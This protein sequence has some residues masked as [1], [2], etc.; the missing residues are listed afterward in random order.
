MNQL[1][2]RYRALLVAAVMAV[3]NIAAG[4]EDPTTEHATA[5]DRPRVGLVLGGGGARGVAHIGVLKELERLRIPIDAIAGTSMGAIVGGLYASGMSA[6]ELEALVG[7]INWAAALR[8]EPAR[9]DLRFRRKEDEQ[10]FPI[11]PDMGI[12]GGELRLPMGLIQGQKLDLILRELTI[13]V[14]TIEDFDE[15]PIPFRAVASDIETG[16][17]YVMGQGDLAV[18]IRASMSVPGAFAPVRVND[19]MLVDGGLAGNLPID[20][21]R[22]MDVDVVIAVDVEFPLY[23]IDELQSA[24]AISEQMLT[25]LIRKETV[26]QIETLGN[27]DV[28]I[29][30][31][32]GIYGSA[33]FANIGETIGPGV[34]AAR[35]Q[36]QTLEHLAVDE[37][38][39]ADWVRRRDKPRAPDGKLAFVRVE[40]DS[41]IETEMI[42]SRLRVHPGDPIDIDVL[43]AE[44]ARLH[45]LAMFEK[46]NYRLV[47][48]DGETG[49]VFDARS[50][51]WGPGFL[52]FGIS[53][54]DD[55]EGATSFDARVR[56][57]RP[58][59]NGLGGEW[60]ADLRLG[61]DPQVFTEFYQ[62]L[63]FDSRFF[64][65]PYLDFDQ[66]NLNLFEEQKVVGRLRIS[67]AT[68]G[69][70]LGAEFGNIGEVR[71]GAFRGSGGSRVIV[72]DPGIPSPDFQTGGLRALLRFD[73]LDKAWFPRKGLRTSIEWRQS[74]PDFGADNSYDTI[75]VALDAFT[76]R[77]KTTLGFGMEYATTL[78]FDGAIQDL[79]RLGGFQRLSGFE[80][81]AVNGPHAALAKVLFYRR[82][83]DSPAG[84][85]DAPVYFGASVEAGN[86]WQSRSQMSLDTALVHGSLFLGANTYIGPLFLAAGFGE[87]GESN[88]YLFIGAPPTSR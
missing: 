45:G 34:A 16:E 49:V 58:A 32:L 37:A 2:T 36:E 13:E 81:G 52:R 42:E 72:G 20:V 19:H 69:L 4:M 51:S 29:R 57:T 65:V 40:Q 6:A 41:A 86:V 23:T 46:V 43:A 14:S 39:Y 88:F 3:P 74:R 73:T 31:D 87:G 60:R 5:T 35:E 11:N 78:S 7:E 26:R 38:E 61:T 33:D 18:A 12:G 15:L 1:T 66:F 10:R 50:K 17:A 84:L 82:I 53:L 24:L 79:F 55:F 83:G 68:A 62:P 85:F 71:V 27:D 9:S 76:S 54:E 48:Q 30:P 28:L 67:E 64:V 47:E 63:R 44:A 22:E 59:V 56:M 80:R 21:I 77:G 8:D 75:D 25:I 70:D